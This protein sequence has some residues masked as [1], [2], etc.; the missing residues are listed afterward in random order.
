MKKNLRSLRA[1][2]K[3]VYYLPI[4]VFLL[5]ALASAAITWYISGH[6][7]DADA[8]SELVL[9]K[10]LADTRQL[11]SRDWVYS[12][13]LR[14]FQMQLVFA[15]L[16]LFLD[17]WR[18]VRFLGTMILQSLYVLSLVYM[19]RKAGFRRQ[20]IW[21][22]AALL[23]LPVSVTYGRIV[24][25]HC[26][27]L[28]Y[29]TMSFFMYGMVLDLYQSWDPRRLRS[30]VMT[31]VLMLISFLS[32]TNS[33]RQLMITHVP[34]LFSIFLLCL[35][36]DTPESPQA[37]LLS[38]PALRAFG[39]AL[40]AA[41]CSF[42]ALLFNQ[43]VLQK[44]YMDNAYHSESTL[45]MDPSQ[46][47]D[48][49]Y[50]FLHQFGFRRYVPLISL[51]GILSIGSIVAFGYTLY[52]S[53]KTLFPAGQGGP[54]PRSLVN[55]GFFSYTVVMT[56][57]FLITAD[58]TCYF[59]LYLSL[60][61]PWAVIPLVEALGSN[62]G[63][64]APLHRGRLFAWAAALVVLCS[65]WLNAAWFTGSIQ[66]EQR[67]EGLWY[68]NPDTVPQLSGATAFLTDNGYEIGYA[69]YWNA[70]IVTELTDGAVQMIGLE[71]SDD[72]E[73]GVRYYTFL[74]YLWLREVPNEK[75]FL[76]VP[77]DTLEQEWA[78]PEEMEP[79]CELVYADDWYQ[80]YDVTDFEQFQVLLYS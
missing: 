51:F 37:A 76:L 65:G 74:T 61:W 17:S 20:T 36:Q 75:P 63:K 31:G 64:Y 72:P 48:M 24:L 79:Y 28:T 5:S 3:F 40:L 34:M 39:F 47:N 69:T 19:A 55:L 33:V 21:Y 41:A 52:V 26:Y 50:G 67:Y 78:F 73:G 22:G 62:P 80:I 58:P 23:L 29:I 32:G 6:L 18:L 38:K 14:V 45:L 2:G 8:S 1:S 15:P 30:W 49:I 46:L 42:A 59:P 44:Y 7:L 16:M 4:L 68:Q 25:Y 60:S 54:A 9:A 11:L 71:E 27:Y 66:T 56:A 70:N 53:G 43:R 35:R 57:V 77:F 13:E 12:T 10:H